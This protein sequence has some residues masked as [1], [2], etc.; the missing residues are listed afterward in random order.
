MESYYTFKPVINQR[1][2]VIPVP[3]KKIHLHDGEEVLFLDTDALLYTIVLSLDGNTTIG[4]LVRSYGNIAG[5][6]YI[7]SFLITLR[8]LDLLEIDPQAERTEEVV[9]L[10]TASTPRFFADAC[11]HSDTPELRS[12]MAGL[13]IGLLGEDRCVEATELSLRKKGSVR[14][15]RF[16][17]ARFSAQ[18]CR[19]IDL[20][21]LA[22]DSFNPSLLKR[23]GMEL[24]NGSIPHILGTIE[25]RTIRI[26]PVV[27]PGQQPCLHCYVSRLEEHHPCL[28]IY[29]RHGIPCMRTKEMIALLAQSLADTA[30]TIAFGKNPQDCTGR[31]ISCNPLHGTKTEEKL[32]SR[33]NCPACGRL[34]TTTQTQEVKLVSRPKIHFFDGDHRTV[35]PES[36][37]ERTKHLVG[38][39][40]LIASLQRIDTETDL[41]LPVFASYSTLKEA[42]AGMQPE[43]RLHCGKG[44]G[45]AQSKASAVFEAIERYCAATSG[46]EAV[47]EASWRELETQ[48]TSMENLSPPS[49]EHC[50]LCRGTCRKLS[51][52]M[53]IEWVEGVSLG[54]SG[55]VAIPANMIFMPYRPGISSNCTPFMGSDSNG[56]A[57]GNN[58]EEA[59]FH[60]VCEVIERDAVAC[61]H[62]ASL[63][64]VRI[65]PDRGKNHLLEKVLDECKDKN[66]QMHL[67][68]L[69]HALIHTVL[70][71]VIDTQTAN[72]PFYVTGSSAHPDPEMA[73]LR[74][75]TEANHVRVGVRH[76]FSSDRQSFDR[77]RYDL[78][79]VLRYAKTDQ[80]IVMTDL[81]DLSTDDV[82]TDIEFC[83][84]RLKSE[85]SDI[86]LYNL[87][88]PGVDIPVVRV[89]CP[90]LQPADT[91]PC[92]RSS[93][94]LL[95]LAR[96]NGCPLRKACFTENFLW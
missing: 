30:I 93:P 51:M 42:Q 71:V 54:M 22:F 26:G 16:D 86:W 49:Y 12:G 58:M 68:Y 48:T 1:F 56:L 73:I 7:L 88:Q 17:V 11:D 9:A 82:T 15:D 27:L 96:E 89:V 91:F 34:Q 74:A 80:R 8:K 33:F 40:G 41:K 13:R 53:T 20:A 18:D 66:L 62:H 28:E 95:K 50:D 70:A 35:S 38:K 5:E 52:E 76:G 64:S 19:S 87:T 24:G 85:G 32:I 45:E 57:A 79:G 90:G 39:L 47:F 75:V 55:T 44:V 14:I 23:L 65:I 78:D 31:V 46:T 83:L 61:L 77:R 4:D 94:R 29:S 69:P 60:A 2:A 63:P 92:E 72:R 81:A 6:D 10:N 21:I 59:I 37:L 67:L 43:L 3:G 36:S 25:G 84:E